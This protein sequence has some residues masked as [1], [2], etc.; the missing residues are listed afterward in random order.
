MNLECDFIIYEHCQS[1]VP[2]MCTVSYNSITEVITKNTS[3]LSTI[4]WGTD[5]YKTIFILEKVN[6]KEIQV[7]D[8]MKNYCGYNLKY[9]YGNMIMSKDTQNAMINK[10]LEVII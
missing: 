6:K 8:F 2:P 10:L 1:N 9:P 5:I 7:E 3:E 4:L